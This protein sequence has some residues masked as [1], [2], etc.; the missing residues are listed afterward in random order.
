MGNIIKTFF[1]ILMMSFNHA[2]TK[3]DYED[4]LTA[5]HKGEF[6]AALRLWTPLAEQGN[7]DAQYSLGVLYET[8]EGVAQDYVKAHMWVNDAAVGGV[9]NAI[10]NRDIIAKL[11][12]PAQIAEAQKAASLCI[13][14]NF[15]NC[16]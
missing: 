12:T 1:V 8:G 2:S 9:A 6:A 4:G 7:A 16:D 5:A 10:K 14:Q 15:K 3:N 13:K 11:M